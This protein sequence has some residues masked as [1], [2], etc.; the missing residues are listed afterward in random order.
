MWIIRIKIISVFVRIIF[1]DQDC[2]ALCLVKVS[3]G[4]KI[5]ST[6][7]F[8]SVT[9]FYDGC[10]LVKFAFS[11]AKINA[12]ILWFLLLFLSVSRQVSLFALFQFRR[13]IFESALDSTELEHQLAHHLS[14]PPD[15][16]LLLH[17]VRPRRCVYRICA[18]ETDGGKFPTI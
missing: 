6:C 7:N 13:F 8:L 18:K 17:C 3:L 4:H 2:S 11:R 16:H 9:N 10:S 1:P 12:F 15:D 14:R 5:F